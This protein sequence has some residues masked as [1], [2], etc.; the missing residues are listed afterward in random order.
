MINLKFLNYA[1]EIAEGNEFR[2]LY[3]IANTMSLRKEGRTKIYRDM[4]ADK[5]GLSKRQISRLTDALEEK[6]LLRKDLIYENGKS[7]C[8]YSLN[9]DNNVSI[10][11]KKEDK[12][13][14]PNKSY[15]KIIKDTKA[16]KDI[17]DIN[18][19]KELQEA[20]ASSDILWM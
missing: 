11:S 5:L 1:V 6:G 9:L 19:E 14:P 7:V 4:L 10:T 18:I 16:T 12:N 15:K 2:L 20:E 13:V 3:L 17:K 8:F